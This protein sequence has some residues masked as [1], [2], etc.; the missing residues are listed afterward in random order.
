[1]KKIIIVVV[2]LMAVVLATPAM[3]YT[4][5][6]TAG[7]AVTINAQGELTGTTI[8][9]TATLVQQGSATTA[10]SIDFGILSTGGLADSGEA[11]KIKGG[12]NLVNARVIIYTENNLN[13][14]APNKAPTVDPNTGIDGGGLVGQTEPGYTVALFWGTDTSANNAPNTNTDYVFGD[15]QVPV[16]GGS[17]NCNYIVDKRHTMSFTTPSAVPT[18]LDCKELYEFDGTPVPNTDNDGL[19][20]QRWDEDLYDSATVHTVTTKVSPSLY[21]TIA[22]IA[23]GVSEGGGDDA[24]YYIANV[25]QLRTLATDDSITARLSK[26]DVSAGGELYIAMGGDFTSKPAQVYSTAKLTVAMV[27]D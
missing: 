13:T 21:S 5:I 25:P 20:P 24:G 8:A 12:T 1:M 2:V 10:T 26:T 19:Y 7:S 4:V 15:P 27:Q 11:I 22:T 16:E 6:P 14:V 18:S 3:A 23:F 9:F 17:G